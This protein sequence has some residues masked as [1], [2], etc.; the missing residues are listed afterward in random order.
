MQSDA[1]PITFIFVI[2]EYSGKSN[3]KAEGVYFGSQLKVSWWGNISS[4]R[5]PA[6]LNLCLRI[7]VMVTGA[8]S[9]H[10]MVLPMFR[11]GLPTPVHPIK[12]IPEAR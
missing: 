2:M 4:L 5:Q 3:L 9:A 12:I 1:I 7:R 8:H 11:M 10:G 6:T